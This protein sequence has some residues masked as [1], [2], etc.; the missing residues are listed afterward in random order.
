MKGSADSLQGWQRLSQLQLQNQ[1]PDQAA[2][3][4]AKG[5]KC[6]RQRQNRSYRSQPDI[7]AAIVLARGQS[8]CALDCADDALVMFNALTGAL[9]L[10]VVILLL[11]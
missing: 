1:Q 2:E 7:A 6:L 9:L 8:L 10:A 4:A 5:L 3:S 11:L